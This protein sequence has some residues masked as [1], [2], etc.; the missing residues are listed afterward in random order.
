MKRRTRLSIEAAV[1][2]VLLI[3]AFLFVAPQFDESQVVQQVE[4]KREMLQK[5]LNALME[6][7]LKHPSTPS[8]GREALVRWRDDFR[9]VVA[10]HGLRIGSDG[11]GSDYHSFNTFLPK[12]QDSLVAAIRMKEDV[13]ERVSRPG[14]QLLWALVAPVPGRSEPFNYVFPTDSFDIEEQLIHDSFDASNGLASSG[15]IIT[16]SKRAIIPATGTESSP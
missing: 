15:T 11:I 16:W 3:A 2:I 5:S 7:D 8:G 6:A 12:D 10:S 9:S 14:D 4:V 13:A 1:V